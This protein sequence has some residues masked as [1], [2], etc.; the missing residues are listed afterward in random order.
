MK[1]VEELLNEEMEREEARRLTFS[2]HL[3]RIEF[4]LVETGQFPQEAA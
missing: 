4:F 2:S 3:D 1:T